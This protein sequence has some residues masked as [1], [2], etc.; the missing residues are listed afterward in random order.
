M[1]DKPRS[2]RSHPAPLTGSQ[3]GRRPPQPVIPVI[4][5][6]MWIAVGIVALVTFTASWKTIAGV[7]AIG[8]GVLFLRGGIMAFARQGARRSSD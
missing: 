7:V 2:K 8:V 1:P 5:G 4:T 3:V 6:L